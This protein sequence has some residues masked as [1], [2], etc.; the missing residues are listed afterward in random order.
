MLIS[1]SDLVNYWGVKPKK[2]LHIGAHHAE[3]LDAYTRHNWNDVTW[4]EAQPDKIEILKSIIPG[5]HQLIQAAVWNENGVPL[6]LNVMTNSESTSLLNL[7][8]HAIE[9]P[10]VQFSHSI[11]ILTQTLETIIPAGDT[12]DFI[13]IDIQGAELRALEG[14]APRLNSVRWIY[15]EVNREYL[16]EECCLVQELDAYLQKFGFTRVITRWTY[17][18]WGDALFAHETVIGEKSVSEKIN[19]RISD[20]NWLLSDFKMRI[21]ETFIRTKLKIKKITK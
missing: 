9:H 15:C 17:H 18:G 13:A 4:I 14:F 7:G 5:H 1:V 8:T 12:P 21:K 11:P 6:N 16:Y 19:I 2:V 20:W 10:N 3:E